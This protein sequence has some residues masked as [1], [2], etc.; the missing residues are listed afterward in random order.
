MKLT[1]PYAYI[2]D[3]ASFGRKQRYW[4]TVTPKAGICYEVP[5]LCPYVRGIA[6]PLHVF[7]DELRWIGTENEIAWAKRVVSDEAK[8]EWFSKICADTAK[9][10]RSPIIASHQRQYKGKDCMESW[11]Y[12][13]NGK[14]HCFVR[15][16]L[17]KQEVVA[18]NQFGDI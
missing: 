13:P 7:C 16:F 8:C 6:M 18:L 11:M 9:R 15:I 12:L 17:S 5:I 14:S 2:G 10:W 4:L 3:S 1:R